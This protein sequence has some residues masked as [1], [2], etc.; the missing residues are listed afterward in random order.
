MKVQVAEIIIIRA[1][2]PCSECDKKHVA[3]KGVYAQSPDYFLSSI[4]QLVRTNKSLLTSFQGQFYCAYHE[5]RNVP[6]SEYV[7]TL[8]V[9]SS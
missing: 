7:A 3:K 4:K 8:Q 6:E 9:I 2:G 1:E 5:K